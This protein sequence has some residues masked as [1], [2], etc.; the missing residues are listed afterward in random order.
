MAKKTIAALKEYFKV[1]KR[2]TESQFGDLIDSYANLD[3]KT[4]F[5][6]NHKY[7]DLY[8]EFPHQQGDMAVDVLLGNNYLNGSLEIEITGTFAHQTSVG[9]IK[10]QFEV[11]LNPDGGVWYPTTA[12][13]VEA[14]GTILDNIYI[15]DIVWDSIRNEYKLTIY[16]TSTN[17]NPYAIRIK[18]FSYEKAFVDQARLSDIYVKPFIEQKKHSVY[19]N[20]N[21][22]LGTDNP[23]SK[24][25]V[26]GNVLAGRSDA[27]EGI[28]AFAIRYEN[29][30]VNN[31]GSLRSGAETYMSYGVKADNKTAYGWLSGNGSYAG[32]KTAVTVGGEGIK[33]LSSSYQQAAQDSP[34][35]LSELMRITPNGSVGIGTENPQQKLDV[36][37]SIV[38]QVGSNEGGSIF[39]QNP[40]KTAPGTAH[41]WAIYNMTGGYGN[42]LQFWSYAADGNNYGSRMIIADNGN[43]GIGNASPQAKLDVEGGI[44]IAAGSPIQLGGNT[45]SHGLKYKRQNSDNSLLDG[46]FLYGWTGGAL[47]IKKGDIEFNVLNWKESGNVAIQGKLE[48]KDVVITQTPTADYVFASDYHLRGIKDLGRFI[49]ENKHLPEIP[50][51]KEMTDTGLSVADFQIKLLQKIE[52]MS[53]YIISLDKEIDVLKSK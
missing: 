12:R 9:I 43:V 32:Y 35:A 39:F 53:L 1:G 25:D 29:G 45:S 19:Y 4:I 21:L 28:N 48:A 7:K 36:R 3:D 31:W 14:A 11:G 30:S 42:G 47:G 44:N 23:K 20:G 2:P 13:I 15:G 46:P 49:N 50:S 10:K 41:Q 6:D 24:L 8:V 37:G 27:T 52:E 34:V 16:H 18:Q 51:A 26:W 38:S 17:Q 40:N 5:P 22:G 33:F